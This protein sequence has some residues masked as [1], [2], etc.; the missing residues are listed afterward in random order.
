[1]LPNESAA[2]TANVC[3]PTASPEYD[4]GEEQAVQPPPS[5]EHVN[6]APDSEAENEKPAVVAPVCAAGAESIDVSGGVLSIVTVVELE[7]VEL[8]AASHARAVSVYVPLATR[9][10]SQLTVYGGTSFVTTTLPPARN[11][12]LPTPTSSAA[13]AASASEPCTVEPSA[14]ACVSVT[15]GAVWSGQLVSVPART[16]FAAS[17][18]PASEA[19]AVSSA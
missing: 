10:E 4:A 5:S 15:V 13:L 11:S 17:R 3:V 12:T 9:V 18:R 1:M 6:V 2:R 16:P 8:C 19:F 14:G 7:T